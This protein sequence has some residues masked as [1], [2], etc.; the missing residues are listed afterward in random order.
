M[1]VLHL[2]NKTNPETKRPYGV[3]KVKNEINNYYSCCWNFDLERSKNL[4]GGMIYLHN[5]KSEKSFF[6]GKVLEVIP[7]NL[8]SPPDFVILR[9]DDDPKQRD[10]VMFKFESLTEGK[11][12]E[13]EGKDHSMSWTS[14]IINV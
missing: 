5:S 7:V 12:K 2:I 3:Y 14:G 13:W 4:I 6:G 1:W 8:D 10:R 11:G 9:T